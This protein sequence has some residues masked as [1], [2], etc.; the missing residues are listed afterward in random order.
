[1][2][3]L[4][5][6]LS[7]Y[8]GPAIASLIVAVLILLVGWAVA[9]IVARIVGAILKRTNLDNR[10]AKSLDPKT[11]T[12]D[13][14]TGAMQPAPATPPAAPP[15]P[16]YAVESWV[17]T[18]VFWFVF[19]FFIVAALDVLG[20]VRL[21]QPITAF[22]DAIIGWLPALFAALI[23]AL[24][25]HVLGTLGRRLVAAALRRRN[26]DQRLATSSG[27]ST[28][29]ADPLGDAVYYLVWLI[30]LP[31]I[32]GALGMQGLL[33]PV[34][35]MI[36]TFL[37]FLPYLAAAAILLVVGWFVARI[38]QRIVTGFLAS[39]GVDRFA[40]RVG[41]AKYM[42]GTTLSGL[43][44][45]IVFIL[46]LIP[47]ITAA[48][49]AL[50][51]QSLT[52]PLT[53]MMNEVITAIPSFIQAAV[54]L[55]LAFVLGRWL[56]GIGVEIM[57]GIGV[58]SLPRILGLSKAEIIGG[59]TL[60]Q[61]IGDLVLLIVMLL[62]AVQAAQVVGW[63]AVTVA[64]GQLGTQVVEIVFG[65]II[66]AI[67]VYLGNLAARF[68]QGTTMPN[69]NLLAWGARLA[70]IAFAGAM[71][72]TAMGFAES[73][74]VIAFGLFFGAIA[75]AVALAFGLGGRETAAKQV[76][77]WSSSLKSGDDIQTPPPTTTTLS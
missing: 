48:L 61:W 14:K 17:T 53:A 54:I 25:A 16:S 2:E 24:I 70:I 29:I 66:I 3:N 4:V 51:M 39:A 77:E 45:L 49:D 76:A 60:A 41:V 58:N 62:A 46:I 56:I 21:A 15:A 5:N 33:I 52:A 11:M 7:Q 18:A 30:F 57:T 64:I 69:K 23:L 47:I 72:L 19:L 6:S 73:I 35:N 40:E 13:P 34:Q 42:G 10:L 55:V 65:L 63:T 26:V 37:G 12:T 59:R 71:G 20:F 27:T 36:D 44:G 1:M 28:S 67:G 9:A 38:I 8:V 68:V 31:A 32:L 74:V 75:V 43:L 22:L 50:N